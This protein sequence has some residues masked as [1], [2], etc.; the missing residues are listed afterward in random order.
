MKKR[1]HTS[2]NA[3]AFTPTASKHKIFTI[4]SEWL[5]SRYR[6]VFRRAVNFF[7]NAW[8]LK[9]QITACALCVPYPTN[10][11]MPS[12]RYPEY[13]PSW[14]GQ[15][16]P[17]V[18]IFFFGPPLP[19]RNTQETGSSR[20]A[21][22]LFRFSS[23]QKRQSPA[24]CHVRYSDAEPLVFAGVWLFSSGQWC[25]A[26]RF[27]AVFDSFRPGGWESPAESIG[28]WTSARMG[29]ILWVQKKP[30]ASITLVYY[31]VIHHRLWT[32][33]LFLSES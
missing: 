23:W 7:S 16:V 8:H 12:S 2:S 3:D 32:Y 14:F 26:T 27:G 9:S 33:P 20:S 6:I 24:T 18:A 5:F 15:K 25:R 31:S 10:A 29:S 19:F 22:F 1:Y 4:N 11:W 13:S 30:P 21:D 28:L 17:L